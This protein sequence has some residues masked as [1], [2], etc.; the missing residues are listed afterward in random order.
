MIFG[1]KLVL[2]QAGVYLNLRIHER[3]YSYTYSGMHVLDLAEANLW[4]MLNSIYTTKCNKFTLFVMV[5]HPMVLSNAP[6]NESLTNLR[7]MLD[8]PTPDSCT[9]RKKQS[10]SI[11]QYILGS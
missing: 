11:H 3:D 7:T 4:K 1:G 2:E 10:M 5:T 8:F 9:H 6:L